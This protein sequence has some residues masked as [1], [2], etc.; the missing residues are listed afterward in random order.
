VWIRGPVD[1]G[2]GNNTFYH[3]GKRQLRGQ[4]FQFFMIAIDK[5]GAF[6][7]ILWKISVEAKPEK[8]CQV[9]AAL[10]RLRCQDQD[11]SR[12]TSKIADGR[13][14]LRERYLRACTL[15]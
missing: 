12:I 14:E 7:K 1:L 3:R 9:G 4:L 2:S 11:A 13:I 8:D 5:T 15:E 6:E 10:L